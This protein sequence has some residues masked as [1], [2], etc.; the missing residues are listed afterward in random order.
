M[1]SIEDLLGR[2]AVAVEKIAAGGAPA[3]KRQ[4]AAPVDDDDTPPPAK[5]SKALDY[6]RDVK[7]FALQ[8]AKADRPALLAI[9]KTFGVSVGT[10]LKQEQFAE[11]AKQIKAALAEAE[12]A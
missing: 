3:G 7:P 10:E 2:I 6:V 8:L 11:A 4:A 1:S 5:G 12:V 9:Y